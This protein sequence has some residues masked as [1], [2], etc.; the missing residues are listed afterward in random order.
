MCSPIVD[1]FWG[2]PCLVV[3]MDNVIL[4]RTVA[5]FVLELLLKFVLDSGCNAHSKDIEYKISSRR[6]CWTKLPST[7]IEHCVVRRYQL[8]NPDMS[9]S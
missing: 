8:L 6:I 2:L 5:A 7:T 4:S 9:R 1:N 3:S